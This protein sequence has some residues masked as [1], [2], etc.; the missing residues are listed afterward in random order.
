MATTTASGCH[1]SIAP[2]QALVTV[3]KNTGTAVSVTAE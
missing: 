1:R 2:V 3:A